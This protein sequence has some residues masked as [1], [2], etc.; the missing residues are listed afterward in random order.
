MKFAMA[1]CVLWLGLAAT[2]SAQIL[3]PAPPEPTPVKQVLDPKDP[4]N[5]MECREDTATGSRIKGKTCRTKRDWAERE[6]AS[7]DSLKAAQ[8]RAGSGFTPPQ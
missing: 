5:V 8:E 2:T 4:G 1:L 3:R 7:K 6:Q